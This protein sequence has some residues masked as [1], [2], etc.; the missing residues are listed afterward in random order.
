MKFFPHDAK[1]RDKIGPGVF[2]GVLAS[3]R[4]IGIAVV[5]WRV[6]NTAIKMEDYFLELTFDVFGVQRLE[7]VGI[8]S[9]VAQGA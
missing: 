9:F 2:G 6:V 4:S 1:A 5:V 3:C 7:E 8:R